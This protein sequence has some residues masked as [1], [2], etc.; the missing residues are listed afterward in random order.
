M[1]PPPP[2][3]FPFGSTFLPPL[4]A[5]DLPL[6]GHGLPPGRSMPEGDGLANRA[7]G[8]GPAHSP[9]FEALAAAA[10][11]AAAGSGPASRRPGSAPELAFQG[12]CRGSRGAP[13][14]APPGPG[15]KGSSWWGNP[16]GAASPPAACGGGKDCGKGLHS[17]DRDEKGRRASSTENAAAMLLAAAAGM[18]GSVGAGR[19]RR[20]D[21]PGGPWLPAAAAGQQ[22][23]GAVAAAGAEGSDD[24]VAVDRRRGSRTSAALGA[25]PKYPKRTAA[26]P[27]RGGT[28]RHAG[29]CEGGGEGMV[30]GKDA[31]GSSGEG[32]SDHGNGKGV[33]P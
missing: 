27:P 26:E 17:G 19:G 6:P 30:E 3:G 12:P 5:E 2:A 29:A 31:D 7:R 23:R 15:G 20:S 33:C 1:A 13:V 25:G 16:A 11:V 28:K 9:G 18:S 32:Y 14:P 21:A 22:R 10:A 24:E 8:R 4:G